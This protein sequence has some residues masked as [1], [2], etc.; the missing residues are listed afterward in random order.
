MTKKIFLALLL[1]MLSLGINAQTVTK[2]DDGK[3]N[4]Y[5]TVVGYNT[6]GFGKLKVILDM[7][8]SSKH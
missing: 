5:C 6:F 2:T 7:G 3:Y 8:Y 1:T 4:V